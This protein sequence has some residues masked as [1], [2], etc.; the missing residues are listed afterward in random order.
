VDASG[1]KKDAGEQVVKHGYVRS[2]CNDCNEVVA[3]LTAVAK[4]ALL[5]GDFPRVL[6][7]LEELGGRNARTTPPKATTPPNVIGS[8]LDKTN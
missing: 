3:R 6:R 2:R 1:S 4:N 5:N 8:V 7:V